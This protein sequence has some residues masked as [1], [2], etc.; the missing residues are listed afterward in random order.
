[1]SVVGI[2][3]TLFYGTIFYFM[4]MSAED[5]VPLEDAFWIRDRFIDG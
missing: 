5:G 3:F 1:M 4:V 2:V